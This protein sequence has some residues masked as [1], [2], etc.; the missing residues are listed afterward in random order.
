MDFGGLSSAPGAPLLFF[1]ALIP[2]LKMFSLFPSSAIMATAPYNYS[3]IFKYIIIG[4]WGDKG[5]LHL[6]P[7]PGASSTGGG[8]VEF[9]FSKI[10]GHASVVV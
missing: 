8:R 6:S 5:E 4:E 1:C 2:C 9:P 3:Y 10:P 7:L